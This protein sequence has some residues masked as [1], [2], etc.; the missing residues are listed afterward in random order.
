MMTQT[1]LIILNHMILAHQIRVIIMGHVHLVLQNHSTAFVYQTT[2]VKIFRLH[3]TKD[4]KFNLSGVQCNDYVTTTTSDPS[5]NNQKT[6]SRLVNATRTPC[7]ITNGE[8]PCSNNG[9]CTFNDA[10]NVTCFCPTGFSGTFLNKKKHT[11]IFKNCLGPKCEYS[12]SITR[13]SFPPI[14]K[15]LKSNQN[16]FRMKKNNKNLV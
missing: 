3:I 1:V 15:F 16:F 5:F 4:L 9:L 6:V 11:Y 14:G 8:Y 2:P 10:G 7:T 12:S 13:F